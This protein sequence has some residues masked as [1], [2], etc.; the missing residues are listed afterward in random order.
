MNRKKSKYKNVREEQDNNE[1]SLELAEV[2]GYSRSKCLINNEMLHN[3]DL[4][5]LT[6]GK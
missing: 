2:G 3:T 1:L 5:L 4:E 6:G